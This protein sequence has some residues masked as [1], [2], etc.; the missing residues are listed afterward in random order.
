ME[1]RYS[2]AALAKIIKLSETAIREKINKGDIRFIE[3]KVNRKPAKIVLLTAVEY[4]L[5]VEDYGLREPSHAF[6]QSTQ[7][8]DEDV[9]DVESSEPKFVYGHNKPSESEVVLKVLETTDNFRV[10][11]ENLSK[12]FGEIKEQLGAA[13]NEVKLLTQFDKSKDDEINKLRAELTESLQKFAKLE[14]RHSQVEQEN[15]K[16]KKKTFFGIKIG[17]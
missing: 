6:E 16:L 5:L 3:G 2:V 13:K 14:E 15:M 10:S 12:D 4:N 17:K 1:Q 11:Y 9:I 8:F 7:N